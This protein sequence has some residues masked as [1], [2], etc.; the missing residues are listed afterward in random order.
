[1]V[2]A[3]FFSDY[4]IFV[5]ISNNVLSLLNFFSPQLLQ[6]AV[7][8]LIWYRNT[9]QNVQSSL[10]RDFHKRLDNATYTVVFCHYATMVCIQCKA[11]KNAFIFRCPQC[12]ILNFR[13]H[14]FSTA[15]PAQND[16]MK[17]VDDRVQFG[18]RF[19]KARGFIKTGDSIIGNELLL[20]TNDV[21]L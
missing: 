10:L 2:N 3:N 1:M 19:G 8:R 18:V 4:F 14:Y 20:I 13:W 5:L 7:V 11:T 17:D 21:S 15:E 12:Q 16:W 6:R 9:N